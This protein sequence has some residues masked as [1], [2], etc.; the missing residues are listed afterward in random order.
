MECR[1]TKL[2]LVG[3]GGAGKTSL[4]RALKSEEDKTSAT[5]S[6]EITDGIDITDWTV[7]L[8]SGET[9]Q[10]ST[11]DFA[12]QVV[13]YNTHQFFLS[14]RAVY[15]LLWTVRLGHEHAGLDFWLS[16]IM[17]HA[18]NTPVFVVG[19]HCDQVAKYEIPTEEL[20]R[21]YPQ[22]IGFHFV[23]CTTGEGI[24]ELRQEL[25]SATLSQSYMGEKIPKITLD[26][27]QSLIKERSNESILKWDEVKRI[28]LEQGLYNEKDVSPV[29]VFW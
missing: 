14:K 29:A 15:L 12:G 1:R 16:S 7:R 22:I 17:C 9:V 28:A 10:Y 27:E 23:S 21:R 19:T 2:M 5:S 6:E 24:K 3:L 8:S 4:L 20:K 18:P 11:W 13:Y 26:F 25:L